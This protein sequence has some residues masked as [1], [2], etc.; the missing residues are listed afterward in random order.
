MLA[1]NIFCKPSFV[2]NRLIYI[3]KSLVYFQLRYVF[4]YLKLFSLFFEVINVVYSL[5]LKS[6]CFTKSATLFWLASFSCYNL[7]AKF[8]IVNSLDS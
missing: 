8:S 3:D 6:A 4:F 7:S 5:S 2:D 1:P